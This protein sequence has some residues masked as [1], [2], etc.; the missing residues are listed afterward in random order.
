MH[1]RGLPG[2][3]AVL[4]LPNRDAQPP[5]A[6][7]RRAAAVAAYYSKGRGSKL[8]PVMVT[9]RKYVRS[10]SGSPP[11]AVR[12]EREEVLLVEPRLPG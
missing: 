12:A 10:P 9:E 8:V 5:K 11:G 1:A 6:V 3:P 4:R 7:V 2:A